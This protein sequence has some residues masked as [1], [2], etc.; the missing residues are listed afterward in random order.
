VKTNHFSKKQCLT[1]TSSALSTK[2]IF[3]GYIRCQPNMYQSIFMLFLM[4]LAYILHFDQN[5]TVLKLFQ[6]I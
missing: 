4:Y 5:Y 1:R 3:S 6:F 2:C